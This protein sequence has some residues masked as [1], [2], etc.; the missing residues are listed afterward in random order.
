[1]GGVGLILGSNHG[2]AVKA[3]ANSLPLKGIPASFLLETKLES[4]HR[5]LMGDGSWRKRRPG[6][7]RLQGYQAPGDGPF[8][9]FR[10]AP[11]L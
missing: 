11:L 5:W 8:G 4:V 3:S 9:N 6:P 7:R 2:S 1:M 10:L